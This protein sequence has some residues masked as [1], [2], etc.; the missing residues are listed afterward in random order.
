MRP[1]AEDINRAVP[2]Y[3]HEPPRHPSARGVIALAPFPGTQ[4]GILQHLAREL[5]IAHD[6]NRQ[7]VYEPRSIRLAWIT[8]RREQTT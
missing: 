8:P 4:E 7:G 1:A 5:G 6:T 2:R 3:A